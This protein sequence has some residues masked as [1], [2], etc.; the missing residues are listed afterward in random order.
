[1]IERSQCMQC[2]QQKL[3]YVQRGRPSNTFCVIF[4]FHI[5]IAREDCCGFVQPV[6]KKTRN[7]NE[8]Q[9]GF[10]VA[11]LLENNN[12]AKFYQCPIS[13]YQTT[14][15]IIQSQVYTLSDKISYCLLCSNLTIRR[16]YLHLLAVRKDWKMIHF[17]ILFFVFF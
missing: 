1:M 16:K 8:K 11:F 7:D 6:K 12:G 17:S 2:L 4:M 13:F 10:V 15:P 5:Q 14:N 3:I 9:P